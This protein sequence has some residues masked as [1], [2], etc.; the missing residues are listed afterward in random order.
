MR[1][2]ILA[3]LA[4]ALLVAGFTGGSAFAFGKGPAAPAGKGPVAPASKLATIC[5]MDIPSSSCALPI[6]V[7]ADGTFILCV[8]ST[9]PY[10]VLSHPG[11]KTANCT[12]GFKQVILQTVPQ[13]TATPTPT[14][15]A[16]TKPPVVVPTT[17]TPI[18]TSAT[19]TAEAVKK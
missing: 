11:V 9:S 1:K 10:E 2:N 19:P 12:A 18:P 5:T 14:A 8:S 7:Y 6:G 4:V 16:T 15:S 17:S 3:I 13:V